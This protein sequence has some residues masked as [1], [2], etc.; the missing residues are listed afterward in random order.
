[1]KYL[2]W[3]RAKI[4]VMNSVVRKGI[5]SR[6]I[7]NKALFVWRKY[8]PG[9]RKSKS[10]N[11]RH[12]LNI[13]KPAKKRGWKEQRKQGTEGQQYIIGYTSNVK[14]YYIVLFVQHT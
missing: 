12:S 11:L 1:M 10:K 7:L 3:S 13:W 6:K 8:I 14:M 9:N 4:A 2:G 5:T